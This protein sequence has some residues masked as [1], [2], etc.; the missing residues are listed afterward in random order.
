MAD[1]HVTVEVSTRD[2][3]KRLLYLH[4]ENARLRRRI[5]ADAATSDAAASS[6]A[7]LAQSLAEARAE[8]DRLRAALAELLACHTESAGWN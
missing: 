5:M 1:G 3:Q 4:R 7:N 6:V 2:A 8:I